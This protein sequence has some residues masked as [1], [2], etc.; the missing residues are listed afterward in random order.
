MRSHLLRRSLSKGLSLLFLSA[1]TPSALSDISVPAYFSEHMMLQADAPAPVWGW[2]DPGETVTATFAGQTQTAQ[3]D[4]KGEWRVTFAPLKPGTNGSLTLKGKNTLTIQDVLAGEVWLAS[5]QSNMELNLAQNF[6]VPGWAE[7]L[8]TSADP[9][10]RQFTVIRNDKAKSAKELAGVW[11]LAN[12]ENLTAHRVH[13]DSAVGYFFARETRRRLNRPVGILHASIGATPI[14]TW[15]K[16]GIGFETMIKPMAPYSIRGFLWYQ[17]ESNVHRFTGSRYTSLFTE[18]V[19]F[20][21]STWGRS[22]LPFLYVQIAP[23]RYSTKSAPPSNG[24]PISPLE[25]PLFWEAQTAALKTIPHSGM[26]VIH[27]TITDLDNIHPWNKRV[28]GERLALL[29]A[30]QVYGDKS[31]VASGPFFHSAQ[32]EGSQIRIR[33]T[34]TG[35]GLATRNGAA[36]D[37]FEIAGEDR[38]FVPAEVT[39][40]KDSALV[41]SPKVPKPVA[42]RFAWHE[43]ARP[44]LMN[45][46]GLPAAPFR[47]DTWLMNDP[48]AS[49]H[50]AAK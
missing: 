38:Q 48:R 46:E 28:P 13:G 19:A 29:A 41:R 22:D 40:E 27:D 24:R 43:E 21:R 16:G 1:L 18:N 6:R 17:G 35:S 37:G 4:D 30:S 49:D 39:L 36:P 15:S 32:P 5:G 44:S 14:E 3:A 31:V 20:W 10:V 26:A 12:K 11:R 33:F 23:H 9:W 25:L 50:S 34:S 2:A 42:V 47:T 8:A 45:K 7:A